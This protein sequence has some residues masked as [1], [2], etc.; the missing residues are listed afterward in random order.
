[1]KA[2]PPADEVILSVRLKSGDFE[3]SLNFSIDAEDSVKK[4]MVEGWLQLILA[5][6]KMGVTELQATIQSE[7]KEVKKNES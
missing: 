6:F 2:S 7:F 5:S 3:S 1:M 4:A